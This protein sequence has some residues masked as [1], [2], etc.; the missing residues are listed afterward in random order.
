MRILI[1]KSRLP[2]AISSSKISDAQGSNAPTVFASEEAYAVE[3]ANPF[4]L[5]SDR[6]NVAAT[7]RQRLLLSGV[8]QLPFGAGRLTQFSL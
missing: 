8:Y 3:I 4:N 7:P 6:G 2:P 5:R 1:G